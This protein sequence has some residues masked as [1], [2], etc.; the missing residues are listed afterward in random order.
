MTKAVAGTDDA[1]GR[2]RRW[3]TT[4]G[5]LEPTARVE[6]RRAG[7]TGAHECIQKVRNGVERRQDEGR[8]DVSHP[9]Y[10]YGGLVGDG[11]PPT[12]GAVSG[13]RA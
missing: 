6:G 8:R 13:S 12:A 5:T 7:R 2:T 3:S 11:K 10:W 9:D 1:D 4:F